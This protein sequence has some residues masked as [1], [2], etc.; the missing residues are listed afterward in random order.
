MREGDSLSLVLLRASINF[1]VFLQAVKRTDQVVS[2]AIDVLWVLLVDLLGW[3]WGKLLLKFLVLQ[4]QDPRV[5]LVRDVTCLA[6]YRFNLSLNLSDESFDL[7]SRHVVF[8]INCFLLQFIQVKHSIALLGDN[9][10]NQFEFVQLLFIWCWLL[11]GSVTL[12]LP[13]LL[14]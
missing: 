2:R 7:F 9:V 3:F 13:N 10:L 8:I 1:L 6:I 4:D 5:D 11:L 14:E 12:V